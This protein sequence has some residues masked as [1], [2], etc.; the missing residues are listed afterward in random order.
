MRSDGNVLSLLFNTWLTYTW[1]PVIFFQEKVPLRIL[2]G[3]HFP[4]KEI[5]EAV[6]SLIRRGRVR[7]SLRGRPA[8]LRATNKNP[9]LYLW[10][11]FLP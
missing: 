9:P 8:E 2:R 7:R 10:I 1:R 5:R 6:N 11:L 4:L 3:W